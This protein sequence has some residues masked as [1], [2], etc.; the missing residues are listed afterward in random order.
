MN[1]TV[2]VLCT[3]RLYDNH[4]VPQFLP[5]MRKDGF[6]LGATVVVLRTAPF[7]QL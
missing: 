7:G 4:N 5:L 2:F 6:R 3:G 1:V